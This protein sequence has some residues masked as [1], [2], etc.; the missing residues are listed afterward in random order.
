MPD[1]AEKL[2]RQGVD[3]AFNTPEVFDK[4]LK[5]DVEANSKVLRAAGIGGN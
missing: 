1:V 3:I 5:T 2:T 4:I